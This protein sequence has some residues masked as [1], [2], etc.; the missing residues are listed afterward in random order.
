MKLRFKMKK[1]MLD[2][3]KALGYVESLIAIA[4]SGIL[5]VGVASLAS[6]VLRT[7]V[8]NDLQDLA[9]QET[10]MYM[11]IIRAIRDNGWSTPNGEFPTLASYEICYDTQT[12]V[13]YLCEKTDSN[14]FRIGEDYFN[15]T[16]TVTRDNE[17]INI[18]VKLECKQDRCSNVTYSQS[19]SVSQKSD[20]LGSNDNLGQGT[21]DS[22]STNLLCGNGTIDT[23][24]GENC[25]YG[26][27]LVDVCGADCKWRCPYNGT[28]TSSLCVYRTTSGTLITYV[29]KTRINPSLGMVSV[30]TAETN[31]SN[32][33]NTLSQYGYNSGF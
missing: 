22:S 24:S 7:T 6:S 33:K 32:L 17:L 23:A 12:A 8:K 13:Y 28:S 31:L 2:S 18:G 26:T 11:D 30:A 9:T 16:I 3:E 15:K 4:I 14:I 29:V 27:K 21:P 19:I 25:D 5:L 1:I 20:N 10:I